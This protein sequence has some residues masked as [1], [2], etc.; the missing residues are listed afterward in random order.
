MVVEEMVVAS[1]H[2]K[3]KWSQLAA[4]QPMILPGNRTVPEK[5]AAVV[6]AFY[7]FDF[8]L[9]SSHTTVMF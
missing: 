5:L 7:N 3:Y 2:K 8:T 4:V 9:Y 1:E 6:S